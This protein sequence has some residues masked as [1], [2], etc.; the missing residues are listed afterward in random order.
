MDF[1]ALIQ[2]IITL[3]QG[4]SIK[5]KAIIGG[6]IFAVVAFVVFLVVYNTDKGVNEK[7]YSVLFDNISPKDSALIVKQ[8]EKDK[9]DYILKD[10]STILVKDAFVYDQ[11]IKMASQGLPSD[12]KVGFELFDKQEFGATDFDQRVKFLRAIEGELA[13]TIE[14]L[15][16]IS[17]AQVHIALP[18]ESVFVSKQTPPTASVTVEML[19]NMILTPK[20]IQGIKNL[21]SAA[22]PKLNPID[23]KIINSD[24]EAIG[25]DDE[26]TKSNELAKTQLRYRKSIERAYEEKIVN[27]LAPLLGGVEKVVAKVTL[28]F[29]FSQTEST[30]EVFDPESVVRSEQVVEESREGFAKEQI[31]GVPGAVSNIG[32]V[33][34][35]DDSMKEKYQKSET[36]T[37]FEISKKVSSIKGEFATLKRVSTAVVV[38]GRYKKELNEAGV[39]I[40]QY[41]PLT[42]AELN[43]IEDIV[44]KAVGYSENRGD[45]VAV[46]NFEFN[47]ES[48]KI[49]RLTDFEKFM[50]MAEPYLPFI[51]YL[52]AAILLFILYKKVI[53]P[54]AERMLEIKVEED[55]ETI[56]KIETLESEQDDTLDRYNDMKKKVEEQL[57]FGKSVNEADIKSQ[58]LKEKLRG[59]IEEK[60]EDA[61]VLLKSLLKDE[62]DMDG[63]SLS[64][65]KK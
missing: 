64:R 24:G 14:S 29:D 38:D 22:V 62:M 57:G 45:E 65:G 17:K 39:E 20:Q 54:F 2:Q 41:Y 3:V 34:G 35:L 27:L 50:K 56:P 25:E 37:N 32:P 61:A 1:K 30:K 53:V 43:K 4:L 33:Q 60:P 18:K 5:Q 52:L 8:L 28:E 48:I 11:R 49:E 13:T 55:E 63:D 40:A 36:T 44:K 47:P 9:I 7:G 58:I 26:I 6:T 19:P 59:I 31:G 23:V 16:P 42:Q 46:S 12:N 15:K 51:K 10:E 21:V